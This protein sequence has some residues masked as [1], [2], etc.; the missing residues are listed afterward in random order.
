MLNQEPVSL[1]N[2]I[3][4]DFLQPPHLPH[5][6]D[7]DNFLAEYTANALL[8]SYADVA[9]ATTFLRLMHQDMDRVQI[10]SARELQLRELDE[11]NYVFIGS[12]AS[13]PWVLLF[14]GRLNFQEVRNNEAGGV[15]KCFTNRN[16]RPGEQTSYRGLTVTGRDGDDYASI[17]VLP[18]STGRGNVMIIQGLQQEGTEAAGLFLA[19]EDKCQMLQKALGVPEKPHKSIYFEA[20][21][22]IH[23]VGGSPVSTT[24]VAN[25][26]IR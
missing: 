19:D 22:R 15:A 12:P 3:R 1:E 6:D 21:L 2:Y 16:P 25:R 26:V 23:A 18:T 4:R 20:L 13:N 10:R 9:V 7:S 11:G 8:T 17:S 14:E 24:I 5:R